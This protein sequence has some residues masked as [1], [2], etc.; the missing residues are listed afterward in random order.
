MSMHE[1]D[2]LT[3][4]E[5]K[6]KWCERIL[7]LTMIVLF[8]R[9]F[10]LQI[11]KG[12]EMRRLSEQNRVRIKKILAPRGTIFDRTG[13]VLADTRPSFN[14]YLIPEDIKDFTQ[15]VDGSC[16]FSRSTGTRSSRS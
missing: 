12:D 9:L 3:T 6:Y 1:K 13:K 4:R 10:D 11:L 2:E 14:L 15:T 7:V 5:K 16:S 8:M